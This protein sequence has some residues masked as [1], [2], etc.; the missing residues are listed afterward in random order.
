M[1]T[2]QIKT[3]NPE[4]A[5]MWIVGTG[6][7]LSKAQYRVLTIACRNGGFVAAGNGVHKGHVER[8]P[9]SAVLAL[10]RRGYLDLCTASE[11]NIAGQLS[12]RSREKL[13]DALKGQS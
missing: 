8:V 5:A 6:A 2:D 4:M 13:A 11:G 1:I 3:L 10:A 12:K 7:P 9:A